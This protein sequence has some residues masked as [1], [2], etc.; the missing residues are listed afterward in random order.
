M[1]KITLEK[2]EQL[3]KWRGTVADM[4]QDT[5]VE[6]L[7]D[8]KRRKEQEFKKYFEVAQRMICEV[9]DTVKDLTTVLVTIIIYVHVHV[10]VHILLVLL[11]V[12]IRQ[13][14]YIKKNGKCLK[15]QDQSLLMLMEGIVIGIA[16]IL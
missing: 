4:L 7:K 14:N 13:R 16:Y 8:L 1:W 15:K 10:H 12:F 5:I 2:T 9:L 6:S 11:I 3:G